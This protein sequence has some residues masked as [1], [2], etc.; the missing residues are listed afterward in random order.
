MKNLKE[1]VKTIFII[2]FLWCIYTLLVY[3]AMNLPLA[4]ITRVELLLVLLGVGFVLF[5][6]SLIYSPL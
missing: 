6:I 1:T 5:V 2:L 4:A 3:G